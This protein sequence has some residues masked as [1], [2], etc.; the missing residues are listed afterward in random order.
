MAAVKTSVACEPDDGATPAIAWDDKAAAL[1]AGA[2]GVCDWT[3]AARTLA[4]EL[5][6]E[7]SS[8]LSRFKSARMRA[9]V[10]GGPIE[11]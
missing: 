3:S 8:R 7:S 10:K 1:I 11:N 2:E 9:P 6:P 5:A 4:E